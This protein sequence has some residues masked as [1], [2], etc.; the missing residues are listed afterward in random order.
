V[1]EVGVRGEVWVDGGWVGG[2]VGVLTGEVRTGGA[3]GSAASS[4]S[5]DVAL[6]AL[7]VLP[8]S[9]QRGVLIRMCVGGEGDG[10]WVDS[11][12]VGEWV[13]GWV[14]MCSQGLF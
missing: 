8:L 11:W 9:V 6:V 1:D 13:G 2:W 10:V 4:G 5:W 14:E 12:C 3:K 7:H